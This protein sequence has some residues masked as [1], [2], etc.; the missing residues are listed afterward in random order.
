MIAATKEDVNTI[1]HV[2]GALCE[3]DLLNLVQ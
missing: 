2:L 3:E 1:E